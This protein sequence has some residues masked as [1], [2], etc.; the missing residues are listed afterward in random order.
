MSYSFVVRVEGSTVQVDSVTGD[1][2]DGKYQVSGHD[3]GSHRSLNV[4]RYSPASAIV[5]QVGGSV[6]REA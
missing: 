4:T 1:V 6:N 3:E 5:A 2:P